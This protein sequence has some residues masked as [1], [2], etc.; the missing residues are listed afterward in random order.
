MGTTTASASTQIGGEIEANDDG[1]VT[2][3]TGNL[4]ISA[5]SQRT[6]TTT[7]AA[8]T[9][10]TTKKK[11]E[12]ILVASQRRTT[13]LLIVVFALIAIQI[14]TSRNNNSFAYYYNIYSGESSITS[15]T[16]NITEE[17]DDDRPWL[18]FITPTLLNR[19][20]LNLTLDSLFNQ[21][22]MGWEVVVGVDMV[23]AKLGTEEAVRQ[24]A[25][26]FLQGPP[27][28]RYVPINSTSAD[29]G[30]K[31]NGSGGIRNRMI[32][33]VARGDWV[34]FVDDDDT[35][36]PYYVKMLE[37]A[38]RGDPTVD[39]VIFRM[40]HS[41]KS[42]QSPILP[43]REDVE[44]FKREE[45]G[46]SFAVR[47]SVFTDNSS[48]NSVVFVPSYVEDFNFLQSAYTKGRKIL[49]ADFHCVAYFI[50]IPP[51]RHENNGTCTFLP[52]KGIRE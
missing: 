29:R 52:V 20:T 31:G 38:I 42:A 5:E 4:P 43:P 16:T 7:A 44:T 24:K 30:M 14:V 8:T 27:R 25:G 11:E 19:R 26:N 46:I 49:L 2:I 13:V 32:L 36:S 18:S 23:A 9:T 21:T 39:V 51:R 45:V 41:K 48:N 6:R 35:L 10:T 40:D 12:R 37:D 17:E 28:V 1:S 50:H 22:R 33:D 3:I 15:S 47:R 34:A